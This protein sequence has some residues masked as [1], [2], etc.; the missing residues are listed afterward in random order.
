MS[1]HISKKKE[2]KVQT[3]AKA[4]TQNLRN[5]QDDLCTYSW[6]ATFQT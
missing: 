1:P 4:D 5:L 6:I 2:K 3:K